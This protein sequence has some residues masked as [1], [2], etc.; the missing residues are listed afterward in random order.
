[1]GLGD[2]RNR[3]IIFFG[4]CLAL[5]GLATCLQNVLA[6]TILFIGFSIPF[7]SSS[8]GLPGLA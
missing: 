5:S 2:L 6:Q 3:F 8:N 7:R 4:L 1:V